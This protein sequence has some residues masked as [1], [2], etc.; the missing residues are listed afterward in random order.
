MMRFGLVFAVMLVVSFSSWGCENKAEETVNNEPDRPPV[1]DDSA[2]PGQ[3]VEEY[4]RGSDRKM[5]WLVPVDQY[6]DRFPLMQHS[7]AIKFFKFVMSRSVDL[8][9]LSVKYVDQYRHVKGFADF[10][11]KVKGYDIYQLQEKRDEIISNLLAAHKQYIDEYNK[12][13]GTIFVVEKPAQ[14]DEN[15]YRLSE[16][17]IITHME[18]LATR[19][20][21]HDVL[22]AFKRDGLRIRGGDWIKSYWNEIEIHFPLELAKRFFANFKGE[23][24]KRVGK[25]RIK[26]W[27]LPRRQFLSAFGG[28]RKYTGMSLLKAELLAV[29][30]TIVLHSRSLFGVHPDR[31]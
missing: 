21:N 28:M 9:N 23:V 16:E 3:L 25:A 26:F 14:L 27:V 13:L 17:Q 11:E 10:Y 15:S 4:G 5:Y 19:M 30:D 1:S 18:F 6:L 29:D 7:G 31:I 24:G 22:M 20:H 8:E 2:I 12:Y